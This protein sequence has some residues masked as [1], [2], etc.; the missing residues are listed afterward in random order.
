MIQYRTQHLIG[1]YGPV[2]YFIEQLVTVALAGPESLRK[3]THNS[4]FVTVS[5][6]W[7]WGLYLKTTTSSGGMM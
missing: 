5:V 7:T 1:K 6:D 2:L 4:P 3:I